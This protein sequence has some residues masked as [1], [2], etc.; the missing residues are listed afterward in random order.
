MKIL[1]DNKG[2]AS[3]EYLLLVALGLVIIL[4]A[5]S[6]ALKTKDLAELVS[7]K[8]ENQRNET[9]SQITR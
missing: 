3:S 1:R 9:L 6:V 2:Q 4:V 5:V 7:L 8:A